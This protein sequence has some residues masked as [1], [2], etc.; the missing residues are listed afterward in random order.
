MIAILIGLALAASWCAA[1]FILALVVCALAARP[2]PTKSLSRR[3]FSEYD[4][5]NE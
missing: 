5:D 1:G 4:F 2:T 3:A